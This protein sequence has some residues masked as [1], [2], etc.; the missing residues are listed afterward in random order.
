MPEEVTSRIS[1]LAVKKAREDVQGRGWKSARALH[2]APGPGYIGIRATQKYLIYQSAGTKP[3]VMWELEG[4]VIPMAGPDGT[5]F[6]RAT[7]VGQPGFVTLPGGVR[8]WRDQRW[9]HPGIKPK[10]FIENALQSSVH[11]SREATLASLMK[12]LMGGAT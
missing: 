12:I 6:I 2:P 5:N 7:R 3:R 4:K 1:D 11:E 9:K 8:V 10:R